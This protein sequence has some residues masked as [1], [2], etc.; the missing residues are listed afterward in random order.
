[1]K[2]ESLNAQKP[3]LAGQRAERVDLLLHRVADIDKRPDPRLFRLITR[4]DQ[5]FPDLRRAAA[6]VNFRHHRAQ[7]RSAG[8]K[9]RG[10]ALA[11]AAEIDE[12]DRQPA[13]SARSLEHL[14]LQA[15]R[16]IPGRLAAH[17][18][19]ERENQPSMPFNKGRDALGRVE[20]GVDGGRLGLRAGREIVH[21]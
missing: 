6:H 19:V 5:N 15:L 4:M 14:S 9:G 17:G 3:K 18:G 20:K 13:Q 10:P 16:K 12:L 1:M 21:V 7:S 8:H 11:K 2:H